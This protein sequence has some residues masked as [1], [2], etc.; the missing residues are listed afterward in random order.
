MRHIQS[1]ASRKRAVS[2]LVLRLR[3]LRGIE[4]RLNALSEGDKGTMVSLRRRFHSLVI[5]DIV[6]HDIYG[7]L[8]VYL[9][10]PRPRYVLDAHVMA[11]ME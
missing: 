5:Y 2:L 3:A 10:G 6:E 1:Y 9:I 8:P 7:T 11:E 4:E